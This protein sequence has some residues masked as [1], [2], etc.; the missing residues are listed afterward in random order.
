MDPVRVFFLEEK[1]WW[2]KI[3]QESIPRER[4]KEPVNNRTEMKGILL[5]VSQVTCHTSLFRDDIPVQS[6][7][8]IMLECNS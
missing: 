4:E 6:V 8:I 3:F 5:Q 7:G 1:E 2:F